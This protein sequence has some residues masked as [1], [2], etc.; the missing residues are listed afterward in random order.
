MAL[1]RA[2]LE[3]VPDAQY[4][5]ER[6]QLFTFSTPLEIEISSSDLADIE[7]VAGQ[8]VA[9]MEQ[10]E[11]FGDVESSL[12]NGYPEIQIRFDQ[13]RTAA[14]GLTVPD[15]ANRVVAKVRGDVPTEFTWRDRKVDIRVR[16][17]EDEPGIGGRHILPVLMRLRTVRHWT[18][19]C[20]STATSF[21]GIR[22]SLVGCLDWLLLGRGCKPCKIR[23]VK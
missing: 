5:L 11:T 15:V 4:T 9:Q 18:P 17:A 1:V 14:L 3:D 7:L 8:L 13:E 21:A 10:S 19:P 6:P 12:Q 2:V 20:S 23:H 16:V 22:K